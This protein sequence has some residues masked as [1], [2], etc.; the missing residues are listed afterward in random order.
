MLPVNIGFD[1]A[2]SLNAP[3]PASKGGGAM[4]AATGPGSFHTMLRDAAAAKAAA[5]A[6]TAP[7]HGKDAVN[8]TDRGAAAD[9]SRARPTRRQ[10]HDRR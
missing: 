2:T 10:N 3:C 9:A 4:S 1:P 6:N 7:A 8:E 5:P